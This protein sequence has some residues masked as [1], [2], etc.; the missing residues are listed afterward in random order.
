[1]LENDTTLQ[2]QKG[3]I[4]R[5]SSTQNVDENVALQKKAAPSLAAH[6]LKNYWEKKHLTQV[7]LAEDLKGD[8]RILRPWRTT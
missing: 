4:S 8:P 1:M 6:F 7:Q 2:V 3:A 5:W